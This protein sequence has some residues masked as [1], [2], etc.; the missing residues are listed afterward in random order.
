MKDYLNIL[1]TV[2]SYGTVF[3]MSEEVSR[4]NFRHY[5]PNDFYTDSGCEIGALAEGIV[6]SIRRIIPNTEINLF[7]YE[8]VIYPIQRLPDEVII[9]IAD[10]IKNAFNRSFSRTYNLRFPVGD[11]QKF[12]F[13]KI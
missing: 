8:I 4:A 10:A 12:K 5:F 13:E 9:K 3:T 1:V 7:P 2:T 11:T 6:D